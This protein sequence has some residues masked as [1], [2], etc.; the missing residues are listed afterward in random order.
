MF[1]ENIDG[2]RG[3]VRI[4]DYC[5]HVVMYRKNMSVNRYSYLPI[6]RRQ[7]QSPQ[8]GQGMGRKGNAKL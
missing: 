5:V 7:V 4:C 3:I 6:F 8:N 1:R 2:E